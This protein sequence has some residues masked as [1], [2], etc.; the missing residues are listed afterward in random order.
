[1]ARQ[2]SL[3]GEGLIRDLLSQ[4]TRLQ[5]PQQQLDRMILDAPIGRVSV[6]CRCARTLWGARRFDLEHSQNAIAR[7]GI[8]QASAASWNQEGQGS[9]GDGLKSASAELPRQ[10]ELLDEDDQGTGDIPRSVRCGCGT[11]QLFRLD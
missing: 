10:K 7:S 11:I 9:L 5:Q 1:M 2:N 4:L 6:R 8:S 3:G